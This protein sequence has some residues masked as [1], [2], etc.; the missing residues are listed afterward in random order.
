MTNSMPL[1]WQHSW[2]K[3]LSAKTKFCNPL[4]GSEGPAHIV[5]TVL[6]RLLGVETDKSLFILRQ[7]QGISVLIKT[8]QEGN[9]LSW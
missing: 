3:F 5:L 9:W 2:L 1:L 8:R 7:T 6:I 4:S